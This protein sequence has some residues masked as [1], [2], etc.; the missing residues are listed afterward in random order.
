MEPLT[1]TLT[2]TDDIELQTL[3]CIGAL[4]IDMEYYE[5]KRILDFWNSRIEKLNP[6]N[7]HE[8]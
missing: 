1:I 5:A 3:R 2:E 4:L 7:L 8:N 6:K